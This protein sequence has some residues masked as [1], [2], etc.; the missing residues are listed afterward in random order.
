LVMLSLDNRSLPSFRGEVCMDSHM[1]SVC[2]ASLWNWRKG[3]QILVSEVSETTI[4]N[5][6]REV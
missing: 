4:K 3:F 5:S 6:S 2:G 1:R